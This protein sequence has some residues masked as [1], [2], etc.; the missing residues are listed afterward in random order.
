MLDREGLET[1]VR[2]LL[3]SDRVTAQTRRALLE[4]LER[5]PGSPS[6]LSS[7][8]MRTLHAAAGRL[9]PL[10]GLEAALD[11]A[12]RFEAELAGGPGDGWRYA[13]MPADAQAHALGLDALDATAKVAHGRAFADLDG[14]S[15]DA[16]LGDV[17]GGRPAGPAW[18]VSPRLWFEE[19]LAGLSRQAYAHPLV[20]VAIGYE[21]FA[22]AHGMAPRA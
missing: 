3:A 9:V 22:D 13:E 15:Q 20:Q 10:E 8:Q 18:A 2:A 12:G 21:G 16:L 7:E 11:L 17:Q 5:K 4:R 1:R 6:E 14:A 19:L